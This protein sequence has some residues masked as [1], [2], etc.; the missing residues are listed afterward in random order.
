MPRGKKAH[1]KVRTRVTTGTAVALLF[2]S[3]SAAFAAMTLKKPSFNM[4]T[5]SVP[6]IQT[7]DLSFKDGRA[8]LYT[9]VKNSGANPSMELV[10]LYYNNGGGVAG[11]HAIGYD[12]KSA[13]RATLGPKLMLN[14]RST[15]SPYLSLESMGQRQIEELVTDV[16]LNA[17]FITLYVDADSR[18]TESSEDNNTITIPITGGAVTTTQTPAATTPPPS[19]PVAPAT[20]PFMR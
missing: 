5:L 14:N 17:A 4:R 10:A 19:T 16:P 13:D 1:T 3:A 18:V 2:L 12:F 15:R 11:E 8:S 7:A 6:A 9:K 20:P